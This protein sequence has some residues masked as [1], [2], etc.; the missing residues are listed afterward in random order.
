MRMC[1]STVAVLALLVAPPALAD[2]ISNTALAAKPQ[3][4]FKPDVIPVAADPKARHFLVSLTVLKSGER[5]AVFRRTSAA[6][7]TVS[8]REFDCA[9]K[10]ARLVGEGPTLARALHRNAPGPM[11]SYPP[12]AAVAQ[13]ADYVCARKI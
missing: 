9:K 3:G 12:G 11:N 5:R 1:M 2:K 13:L 8:V 10:A 6:G 4:M 7:A